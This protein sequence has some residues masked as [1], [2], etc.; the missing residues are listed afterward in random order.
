MTDDW[1]FDDPRNAAS[2]TT[3]FVLD[4][5][6]I[7]RVYHDYDGGW[8]FHGSPNDPATEDVARVVSLDSVVTRDPAIAQLHDLPFG[9]RAIRNSTDSPWVREKNNPF[10]TYEENGYYLDDAVWLS[11]FRDDL[12]PPS[13]ET[14][15]NLSVGEYVK[16]LFRFAAEDAE[17][18]DHE[19]ERMWVLITD[20]DD[21]GYYVGTV[22]NDPHHSDKLKCGDTISFHPLHVMAVLE[23]DA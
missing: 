5:A 23:E 22:E 7:L 9:W 21:D 18:D 2:L 16:L 20:L 13:E 14:R 15:D 12:D 11:K 17:R 6:P 8:Q 3:S 4:G 10:P 19:T 1:Q